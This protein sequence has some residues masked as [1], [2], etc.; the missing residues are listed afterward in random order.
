MKLT[1]VTVFVLLT[2][3]NYNH[4]NIRF[5]SLVKYKKLDENDYFFTWK[6][7]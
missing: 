7:K 4:L 1:L 2:N 6:K 3:I 5:L